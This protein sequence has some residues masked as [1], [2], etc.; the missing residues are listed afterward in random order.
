MFAR[1]VL[2]NLKDKQDKISY[3]ARDIIARRGYLR[4]VVA[5]AARNARLIRLHCAPLFSI[6]YDCVMFIYCGAV[7]FEQLLANTWLALGLITL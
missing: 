7:Y 6:S 4:A 1:A 3:W 2:A 5:M